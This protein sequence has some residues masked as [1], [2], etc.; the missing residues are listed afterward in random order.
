MSGAKG[1]FLP[2]LQVLLLAFSSAK[3]FTSDA[4]CCILDSN[5]GEFCPTT[6]GVDDYFQKYQT[7][8]GDTLWKIEKELNEIQHKSTLT[9]NKMKTIEEFNHDVWINF[10]GTFNETFQNV[11]AAIAEFERFMNNRN[12]ELRRLENN[13]KLNNEMITDL[14]RITSQL[15]DKCTKP[16][17]DTVQINE[18]PTGQ[19]CQDIAEKGAI[20]SGLY[21][22]KPLKARQQFLVYCEIDDMGRGWT[23]FQRRLDGSVNFHRRWIPYREGFGY[24][25]P[26]G[27]TEFWIGNEKIHLITQNPKQ[28]ILQIDLMDWAGQRRHAKYSGFKVTAEEDKYR[29]LYGMFLEGDAGDAFAGYDFGDHASDKIYTSHNY[30]QFSTEDFDNDNYGGNCAKQDEAGWWMNRCHAGNLNGKY[31]KGG[32]YTAKE[33]GYDDGIIWVTWHDRWY[34][35]KET[36]MKVMP[37]QKYEQLKHTGQQEQ[38]HIQRGDSSFK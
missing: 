23:V 21:Y 14:K 26:G 27:N 10:S 8:V 7:R 34:S 37:L 25:S 18:N 4:P 1:K 30:I 20:T 9:K 35:L 19:D 28:Y 13:F 29:L 11:E 36:T 24:L 3:A 5:F 22:I 33:F 12:L 38:F 6:C 31:H 16:C 32:R 2:F 15:Q 17:V